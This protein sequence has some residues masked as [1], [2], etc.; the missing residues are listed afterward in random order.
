MYDKDDQAE[1]IEKK[2]FEIFLLKNKENFLPISYK[3][4]IKYKGLDNLNLRFIILYIVLCFF[5][6][7]ILLICSFL[8]F[9]IIFNH[10]LILKLNNT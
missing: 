10:I 9:S 2:N 4:K 3:I 5:K 8:L 6:F 1:N 7:L